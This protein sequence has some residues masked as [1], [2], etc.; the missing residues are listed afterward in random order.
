MKRTTLIVAFSLAML[1]PPAAGAGDDSD[2]DGLSDFAEIHKYCTDP[3]RQDSDGDGITDGDWH[4][5]REFTYTVRSVAKVMRPCNL[6][7]VSDEY[8]DAR[9]LS[10]T[11]HYVELEIIHYPFNRNAE[12]IQGS[13]DWRK[14]PAAL[15]PY[16]QPGI[17]TNWDEEL[18]K[19]LI[20]ALEAD[21][22]HLSDL[23]DKE[24]IERV[25]Q[26][27][28][29]R[30]KYHEMFGTYFVHFPEGKAEIFPGLEEA[31]E[32]E[33]G[34]TRWPVPEHFQH[35]LFGKGMFYTKS[36]GSC[37]STAIY[38]TTALRALGIPTRMV[39]A[40]PVVDASDPVQ[41]KM[42]QE[43]I[44][45]H[46][47]RKTLLAA[48]ARMG[49][50]FSAHTFNEVFVG[51]R[52]HRLN[53]TKLG[54]NVYGDGAMGMLTHVHTFNDLSEAD[55]TATWGV[56]YGNSDRDLVF[57]HKNPYRATEIS[58]RFGLHC[59]LANP[60]VEE[61]KEIT[62]I[63]KV[64]ITKAYWFL[65]SERPAWIP[66]ES[67]KK[68]EDGHVLVHAEASFPELEAVYPRLQKAFLLTAEGHPPVP[69]RAER[70]YWSSECYLRIPRAAYA[71]MKPGIPYRLESAATDSE[72]QW[73]VADGVVLVKSAQP[74]DAQDESAESGRVEGPDDS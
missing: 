60:P 9:V 31:F 74:P 48:L 66:E 24:T 22:I 19:D 37:T 17:T 51:G 68:D 71:R 42:V 64:R 27:L 55:L 54:Q 23:T 29:G 5:R 53:Y 52:W 39:V 44:S 13:R 26:W 36:R 73:V 58:D 70:G 32:R 6:S 4:E 41:V 56:R 40:I 62:G 35:E 15:K 28:L 20:E 30:A 43:H 10:E 49:T 57:Q 11:E 67:V 7:V 63:K 3:K 59:D 12:A 65:S 69:L 8:Q 46:E 72:Y 61:I 18:R 45:H 38:L 1:A 33:S 14:P 47:V 21:G 16:L 2:A 34:K 50:S 25:S